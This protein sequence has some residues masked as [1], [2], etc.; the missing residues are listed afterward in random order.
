[1]NFERW[2]PVYEA[3][4]ADFGYG[5]AE[6]EVARD[7]LADL[8]EP[9]DLDRFAVAGETVAIAGAAPVLRDELDWAREA[10]V[11]FAASNAADLLLRRG[12]DVDCMITDLDKAPGAAT[13][14]TH[15]G[16]P[17]AVHAHG[18]NRGAIKGWV[19]EMATEWVLA[20]TQVEPRRPV[21]N[22][23]GFT[24]GDRAAFLADHLGADRLVF[25]G[26]DFDDPGVGAEKRRKLQW[27]ARLLRWLE[28]HRGEQFS[29][30]DG[31]RDG[32]EKLP[33]P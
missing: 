33:E 23:G 1:M 25:P 29:V 31:W 24:D 10:D 14:L 20:T 27:A 21:I 6:D 11:V 8:A 3:I 30:L 18:D 22:V 5:R 9:F 19:P 2:E 26:W 16:T 17:V 4:R 13:D 28:R 32:L 12:I 7:E 15:A